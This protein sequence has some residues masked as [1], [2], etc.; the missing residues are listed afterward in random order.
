MMSPLDGAGVNPYR[1]SLE[2]REL[3][4]PMESRSG[5]TPE[6]IVW[7]HPVQ[8]RSS[9][10]SGDDENKGTELATLKTIASDPLHHGPPFDAPVSQKDTSITG[11]H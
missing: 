11:V 6:S 4:A 7:A 3:N 10:V 2:A 9:R 5:A 1:S 8:E